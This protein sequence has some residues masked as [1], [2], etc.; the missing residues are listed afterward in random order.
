MGIKIL[1]FM[2]LLHVIDDFVLQP[3]CL[4]KM[5]QK[6]WWV[7][8]G[9]ACSLYSQDY[10]CALLMHSVSWSTMIMLPIMVVFVINQYI[11]GLVFIINVMVHYLTDDYKANKLKINL[12]QDQGV[13]LLQILITWII[14]ILFC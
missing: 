12:W 2:L 8:N 5:K 13:H 14:P 1:L 4:S 10:K 7:N 11:L 3:I 9:Y 6:K